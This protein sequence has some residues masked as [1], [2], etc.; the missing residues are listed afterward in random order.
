MLVVD[1]YAIPAACGA[2]ESMIRQIFHPHTYKLE[3][4]YSIAHCTLGPGKSTKPHVLKSSEV[5]YI[6]KCSGTIY[7]D[8]ENADV[9][10]GKS[11]YVPP[12]SGQSI[13][14]TSDVQLEFLCI[15]DPAWRKEDE[16]FD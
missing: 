7:G 16:R 3:T 15:V 8:K 5:Y 10:P 11:V 13:K 12:N 14:N 6:I 9:G 4:R 1:T 2:E